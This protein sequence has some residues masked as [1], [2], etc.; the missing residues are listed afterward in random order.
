MKIWGC[1]IITLGFTVYPEPELI[2]LTLLIDPTLVT[3]ASSW[4]ENPSPS[5]VIVGGMSVLYPEPFCVI[6]ISSIPLICL[7]TNVL[8]VLLIRGE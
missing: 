4:P 3:T 2:I 1:E 8:F 7:T 5:I 6:T